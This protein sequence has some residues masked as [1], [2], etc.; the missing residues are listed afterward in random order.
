MPLFFC[1]KVK[2]FIKKVLLFRFLYIF[3]IINHLKITQMNKTDRIDLLTLK[4]K[5]LEWAE[6]Y[7]T[8]KLYET[9]MDLEMYRKELAIL[10]AE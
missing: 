10:N 1:Y 3:D 6:D 4:I 7:H 9:E 5:D 2:Y 8:R